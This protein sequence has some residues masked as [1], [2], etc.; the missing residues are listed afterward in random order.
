MK[1]CSVGL[2]CDT[3]ELHCN[4]IT[5]LTDIHAKCVY[6]VSSEQ[7]LELAA[8]VLMCDFAVLK[9]LRAQLQQIPQA[10]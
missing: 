2:E 9:S 1:Q 6:F 7:V 5:R 3:C 4:K 8:A 10:L